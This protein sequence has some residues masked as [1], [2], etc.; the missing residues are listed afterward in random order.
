MT[1]TIYVDNGLISTTAP[2]G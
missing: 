1:G 2:R